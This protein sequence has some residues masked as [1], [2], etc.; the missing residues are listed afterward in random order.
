MTKTVMK[1]RADVNHE[2]YIMDAEGHVVGRAATKIAALLKGKH[3]V[4]F[5]PHVD[6]GAGVI[7]LNCDKLKV[8]G[9]KAEDKVYK[10][11]SGYPRGQKETVYKEMMTKRPKNILMHAVKGMLPKTR[12]GARMLKR[13]KLYTGAEHPH[14]AQT[15]KEIKL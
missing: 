12:I 10:R 9:S 7:V 11:F 15:P 3:K 4:D 13:L 5:T 8:T 1:N 14:K 2:W 6:N